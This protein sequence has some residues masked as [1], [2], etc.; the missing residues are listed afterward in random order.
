MTAPAGEAAAVL[1]S[2]EDQGVRLTALSLADRL[3]ALTA[4]GCQAGAMG[5]GPCGSCDLDQQ[6]TEFLYGIASGKGHH[7]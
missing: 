6:I 1:A 2:V 4:T 7:A 3:G 5:L